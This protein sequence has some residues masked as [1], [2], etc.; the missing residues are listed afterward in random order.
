M[1]VF[2]SYRRRDV[3]GYAGRLTDAL[4]HR[5][6]GKNVFYD[7]TAITPGRNFAEQINRALND[8]DA[9]LAVIGPGWATVS[10][11]GEASRLFD[12]DDYVRL[13]LSTALARGI[14]VVPVL[15][16]GASLPAATDLP[17]E[18]AELVQ[19]QAVVLHDETWHRD[20]DGLVRS[21]RGEPATPGQSRRWLTIGTLMVVVLAAVVGA[22]QWSRS[23][24]NE[25]AAADQ[26]AAD[27]DATEQRPPPC[28]PTDGWDPLVLRESPRGEV[29][30]ATGALL[31]TVD[32]GRWR[33][34][35]GSWQVVLSTTME[36]DTSSEE[37]HDYWMYS[38]LAVAKRRFEVTCF[39]GYPEV[40]DS[41]RIGEA[42]VGFDVSCE[43]TGY[44][45]LELQES[46]SNPK[47]TD[48]TEW[49]SC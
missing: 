10:S 44:M 11:S 39:A 18:V 15:V 8:S 29:P 36:N 35:D 9:V 27:Q 6:G 12:A 1:K 45:E 30:K 31:F 47:V 43:P 16:G 4:V 28:G 21:L 48:D 7:V 49:G 20:V 42:V 40:V 26:D 3:G 17:A 2:L 13:E 5:L 22:W 25:Q 37:Y 38:A 24:L 41:Q 33:A 46:T 19:R 34:R 14:P 32:E 23:V